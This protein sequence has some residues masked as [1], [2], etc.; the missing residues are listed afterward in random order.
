MTSRRMRA[1]LA[2]PRPSSRRAAYAVGNLKAEA[3]GVT[4]PFAKLFVHCNDELQPVTRAS[5][6]STFDHFQSL[7]CT[8]SKVIDYSDYFLLANCHH[9]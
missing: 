5:R 1:V 4:R 7:L 8:V 2:R 6:G 9:C 3:A